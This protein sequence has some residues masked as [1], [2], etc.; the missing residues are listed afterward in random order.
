M[1]NF[2]PNR[3]MTNATR[4]NMNDDNLLMD[5]ISNRN[6]YY[7]FQTLF[8][9][10]YGT[11]C[12]RALSITQSRQM[13]EEIVSDVF[14]KIWKNREVLQIK[15]SVQAY[16]MKATYNLS[17]DYIRQATR[18]R[19]L[20]SELNDDFTSDYVSP[21]DKVIGDE[22]QYI[23]ESAIDALPPQCKRIFRMSRDAEMTYAE[24][25]TSLNLSIKTIETHMGR[26][27]KY[28]RATLRQQSVMI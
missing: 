7:A 2:K 20:T 15:V 5:H 13:A 1:F 23:I 21:S 17:I 27:L 14:L 28:L 16:L 10:Y 3:I 22:V 18:H 8:H 4:I 11:L 19:T 6:D 12:N 24:I 9:K 26:S 25:A